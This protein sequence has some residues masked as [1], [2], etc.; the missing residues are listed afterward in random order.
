MKSLLEIFILS[1]FFFFSTYL[2]GRVIIEKF[3]LN[4]EE[5]F[6]LSFGISCFLFYIY[7]F[8]IYIVNINYSVF[9]GLFIILLNLV[10]LF[11]LIFRKKHF[12]IEDKNFLL[13]YFSCFLFLL[14]FQSFIPFYSGSLWFWDWF[15]HYLRTIFFLERLPLDITFLGYIIPSRPPLFN[16]VCFFFQ[17]ITGKDFYIYQIISTLINSLIILSVYLFCKEYFKIEKRNLFFFVI[18][19]C[20]L[21]PAILRQITYTWTKAFSAYYVIVGFYFYLK[22]IKLKNKTSL[23]LSGFLF[24]TGFIVHYSAGPYIVPVFLHLFM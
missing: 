5:K 24:G 6:V 16:L 19:I 18:V 2:P 20:M 1:F 13:T 8:L 21:N 22:F 10:S 14:F 9:N 3:N 12:F 15:E 4:R 11:Y 17:S 23:F 7:G